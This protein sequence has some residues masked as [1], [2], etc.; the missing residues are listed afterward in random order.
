MNT[1]K[2]RELAVNS[3]ANYGHYKSI[4]SGLPENMR[5]FLMDQASKLI[6]IFDRALTNALDEGKKRGI[7]I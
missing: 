3:L 2:L 5:P 1:E 7:I 4:E 6:D